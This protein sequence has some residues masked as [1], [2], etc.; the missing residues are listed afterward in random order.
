MECF[1]NHPRWWVY[2]TWSIGFPF[3]VSDIEMSKYWF[4]DYFV[5]LFFQL[6]V[7]HNL[8]LWN[9]KSLS[10]QKWQTAN[11]VITRA[12]FWYF[13]CRVEKLFYA[14]LWSK[15]FWFTLWYLIHLSMKRAKMWWLDVIRASSSD[16]IVAS[17]WAVWGFIMCMTTTEKAQRES[18]GNDQEFLCLG[19]WNRF[20]YQRCLGFTSAAFQLRSGEAFPSPQNSALFGAPV[21]RV[22]D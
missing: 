4:D 21:L 12:L 13:T 10:V 16:I 6:P 3:V 8:F 2:S 17:L 19:R 22:H 7:K 5:S 11:L 14:T 1:Q 20:Q 18:E 15:T 9:L